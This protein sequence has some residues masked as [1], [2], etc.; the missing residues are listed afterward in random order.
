MASDDPRARR[1]LK[2]IGKPSSEP[3]CNE[4][5]SFKLRPFNACTEFLDGDALG[6]SWAKSR[7]TASRVYHMSRGASVPA[8]HGNGIK[9]AVRDT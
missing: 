3:L 2:L 9:A 5:M 4:Y 1:S 6:Q 7:M 8:Q